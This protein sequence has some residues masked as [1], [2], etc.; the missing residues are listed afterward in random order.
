MVDNDLAKFADKL[1]INLQTNSTFW[2]S[3]ISPYH[4]LCNL[5]WE[6]TFFF[7]LEDIRVLFVEPLIAIFWTFDEVFLGFQIQ[8]GFPCFHASSLCSSDSSYTPVHPLAARMAA[9]PFHPRTCVHALVELD[10]TTGSQHV[11]RQTFFVPKILK[12]VHF[13]SKQSWTPFTCIVPGD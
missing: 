3:E 1:W 10:S 11:T 7:N 9:K 13:Q 8:G 5:I 2:A 6:N 12:I 4:D